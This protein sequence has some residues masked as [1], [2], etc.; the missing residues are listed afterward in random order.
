MTSDVKINSDEMKVVLT[1]RGAKTAK[2]GESQIIKLFP[3]KN[4]LCPVRAIK[5]QLTE[6]QTRGIK[7]S[8][9]SFYEN[10]ERTHITK[11]KV[12]RY[13]SKFTKYQDMKEITGHSFR[14]GGA[15]LR[16]ALGVKL[17]HVCSLGRWKSDSY[18]LY[19]KQ[20]SVVEQADAVLILNGEGSSNI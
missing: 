15:S 2:P 6:A 8:L 11:T 20:Y 17:E 16:Y 7:T 3:M 18:K 12:K 1:I 14:V 13:M 9:F 10:G 5:R 19:I 4:V